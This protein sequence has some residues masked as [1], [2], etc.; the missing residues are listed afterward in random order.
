MSNELMRYVLLAKVS[1]RVYCLSEKKMKCCIYF[2]G[3]N[4]ESQLVGRY[5][6]CHE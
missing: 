3:D 5:C 6:L 4:V 1:L 2:S